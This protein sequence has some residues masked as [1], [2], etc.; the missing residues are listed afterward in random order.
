[1][2]TS[3]ETLTRRLTVDP[4]RLDLLIERL[5]T[6]VAR[7]DMESAHRDLAAI[8][9]LGV[10]R[11][12]GP[13]LARLVA[14]ELRVAAEPDHF[15]IFDPEVD[16]AQLGWTVHL[17]RD[18]RSAAD[19]FFG[20]LDRCLLIELSPQLSGFHHA[21]SEV[22][23]IAYIKLSPRASLTEHEAIIAHELAH[24]Y[25]AS[26]NRFVDEGI[27]VFFQARSHQGRF[28]IGAEFETVQVLKEAQ[29]E[30]LPLR[31]MLA[32]DARADM[33]FDRLSPHPRRRQL[34]YAA[35]H[36]FVSYLL[37]TMGMPGLKALCASLR[38]SPA[39]AAHPALIAKMLD[40]GIETL[41]QELFRPRDL[42]Q[43]TLA[44]RAL[45]EANLSPA[46]IMWSAMAPH[47]LDVL[48][49]RTREVLAQEASSI[50]AKAI[51][52][53]ALVRRVL[54]QTAELCA[55]DFAESRS[56]IYDLSIDFNFP[57]RDRMLLEGWLAIAQ[58]HAAT[59]V[60]MR[61]VSWEKALDTFRRGLARFPDDPEILCASAILHLRG[62][63]EHGANRALALSCLS[64]VRR[65]EGWAALADSIEQ[66]HGVTHAQ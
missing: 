11:T 44:S 58:T 60:P 65:F 25:L 29:G 43:S 13:S 17:L 54:E 15:L 24:V 26:G 23:G 7:D 4:Y 32:H 66:A 63:E 40:I 51:L 6:C 35:A 49:Q 62:P 22:P 20:R 14:G 50:A 55:A 30:V 27:A 16:A 39:C 9:R 1:M 41:D 10:A 37:S 47:E 36:A 5:L 52:A 28:F 59:S 18:A 12:F 53:R 46:S 33:Y 48:V 31:A 8:Q 56:L 45:P 19:R 42:E 34:V 57:D 2:S 61:I 3:V 38:S 64:A 21:C